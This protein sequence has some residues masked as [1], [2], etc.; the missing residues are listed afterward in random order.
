MYQKLF[1]WQIFKSYGANIITFVNL[2]N[3]IDDK[4]FIKN[5]IKFAQT[6]YKH[7]KSYLGI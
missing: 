7:E 3:T 5:W 1:K 4:S 2:K 6:L